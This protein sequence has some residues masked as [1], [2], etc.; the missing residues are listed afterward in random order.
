MDVQDTVATS[1]SAF[2]IRV[3]ITAMPTERWL[4][5]ARQGCPDK[6]G[7][8]GRRLRDWP[9][10]AVSRWN[11]TGSCLETCGEGVLVSWNGLK[12]WLNISLQSQHIYSCEAS[13]LTTWPCSRKKGSIRQWRDCQLLQAHVA[14]PPPDT[15]SCAHT[16]KGLMAC[17]F[18]E[19][20]KSLSSW[21]RRELWLWWKSLQN[22]NVTAIYSLSAK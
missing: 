12:P 9:W 6:V 14:E 11:A 17:V 22:L 3:V 21:S 8:P 16:P 1:P 18:T 20:T 13:Y 7:S 10:F 15:S 19:L 2:K 5:T 4:F